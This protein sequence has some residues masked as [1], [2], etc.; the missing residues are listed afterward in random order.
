MCASMLYINYNSLK[1]F[2]HCARK[3]KES[4]H[5]KETL[6]EQLEKLSHYLKIINQQHEKPGFAYKQNHNS[7]KEQLS[8]WVTEEIAFSRKKAAIIATLQRRKN[9]KRFCREG[10]QNTFRLLRAACC[11]LR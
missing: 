4:Y 3:I 11:L 7:L 2:N 5:A 1:F 9:H 8:E 10:I 6:N